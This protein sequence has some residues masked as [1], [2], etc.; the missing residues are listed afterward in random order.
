M[1]N[2]LWWL[3]N[4]EINF[5]WIKMSSL[6]LFLVS[7]CVIINKC[8]FHASSYLLPE[9]VLITFRHHCLPKYHWLS[10]D[11]IEK[12]RF[13]NQQYGTWIVYYCVATKSSIYITSLIK[14]RFPC[15]LCITDVAK[16][17]PAVCFRP[18]CLRKWS[19]FCPAICLWAC[20]Q[21]PQFSTS[22][23]Q[24]LDQVQEEAVVNLHPW[25]KGWNTHVA[26]LVVLLQNS[27]QKGP[28]RIKEVDS[29]FQQGLLDEVARGCV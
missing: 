27:G 8:K 23:R 6:S 11:K 14:H 3:E 28:L 18:S 1:G 21:R 17:G 13:S 24:V 26:P 7:F 9:K 5:K 2:I 10:K 20:S 29:C 4:W 19:L 25:Q 16:Q 12:L 22:F 15:G